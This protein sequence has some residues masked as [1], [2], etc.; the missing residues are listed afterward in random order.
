MLTPGPDLTA[1]FS[2]Y[3]LG[4]VGKTQIAIQ[5]AYLH[6]NDFELICWLRANDWNTLVNSYVELCQDDDIISLGFPRVHDGHSNVFIAERLKTWFARE[7]TLKWLLIFDNADKIEEPEETR[8]VV[9]LIPRGQ[10]CVLVTSRNRASDG[11]L[12]NAGCEVV[13]MQESEAVQFLLECSRNK[14]P[15]T[16]ENEAK[17]LVQK[18]GCLP[19]AI[20]QAGCYIRTA[21]LSLGRYLS[22]YETFKSDALKEKLPMSHKIYYQATVATTWEL[23]FK[24]IDKQD[25][26]ASEILRLITFFDGAKIQKVLFEKAAEIL[27][28]EWRLSKATP[29]QIGRSFKNLLSYSLVR[30][31]AG[32]DVTIHLLVQQVMLEHIGLKSSTFFEAALKL[33]KSQFPSGGDLENLWMCLEYLSHAQSCANYASVLGNNSCDMAGLLNSLAGYFCSNGQY[34]D[35]ILY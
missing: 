33:I 31:R 10:G 34:D 21:G 25:P 24:E 8:S 15:K 29:W 13:E 30:P 28:N 12:A 26:L 27:T 14:D 7:T 6:K 22:L 32:D 19:L 2:L 1:S 18:L 20:Q 11:E 23:S 16:H 3:G 9:D 35:A 4:G 5:Y 17:D